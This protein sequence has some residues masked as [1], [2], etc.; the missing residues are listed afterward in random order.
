MP[1]NYQLGKIY[2]I[3]SYQTDDIY[4]GSTCENY[5]TSRLCGHRR[6]YRKWKKGTRRFISSFYILEH[7][8]SFITLI[9]NY[10]C[11]TK[12]ELLAREGYYIRQLRCVNKRVA[13]RNNRMYVEEKKD[14]R[15]AYESKWRELNKEKLAA[16]QKKWCDEHNDKVAEYNERKTIWN[17]KNREA[18]ARRERERYHERKQMKGNRLFVE[19]F[20]D[21]Y[22][23]G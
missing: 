16:Y 21:F 10:P 11:N 2:K 1:V 4:I 9:E 5:L 23:F 6:D 8:D 3:E 22:P 19:E 15:R 17:R 13:G 7:D 18:L 12:A 14:E 20:R